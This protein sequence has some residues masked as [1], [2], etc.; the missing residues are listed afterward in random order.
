MSTTD[1]SSKA[2]TYENKRKG[3]RL[4]KKS[5]VTQL[6]KT[7]ASQRYTKMSYAFNLAHLHDFNFLRNYENCDN[8]YISEEQMISFQL[9]MLLKIF[10]DH[11]VS[12]FVRIFKNIISKF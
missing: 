11:L 6:L 7:D 1:L 9:L 10:K 2:T 4:G 12:F 5:T 3:T 8:C